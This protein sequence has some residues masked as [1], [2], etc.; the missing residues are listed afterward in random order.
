MVIHHL[1]LD[2]RLLAYGGR[3]AEAVSNFIQTASVILVSMKCLY[4]NERHF[5]EPKLETNMPFY[6]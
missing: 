4:M 6:R 5:E 2:P 1:V 3:R